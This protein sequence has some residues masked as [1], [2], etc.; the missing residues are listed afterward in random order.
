MKQSIQKQRGLTLTGLIFVGG[1][2]FML[3]I[4]GMKVA[5]DYIEYY[6]TLQNV[7]ATAQDPGLKDAGVAQIRGAYLKRLQISGGGIVKP[8]D[9]DISKEGG[10]VV[11]SF[12]YSKKIPLFSNINL[13]IDFEGSSAAAPS[14]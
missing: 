2:L 4:L 3:A 10:D 13:L 5:P 11:I 1:L 6:T 12:S 8:E 9:L 7:R 14:N